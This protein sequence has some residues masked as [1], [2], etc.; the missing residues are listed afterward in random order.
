MRDGCDE[1][2]DEKE[3]KCRSPTEG[4]KARFSS[5]SVSFYSGG[6]HAVGDSLESPCAELRHRGRFVVP[7]SCSS[8]PSVCD[9]VCGSPM[10]MRI[11]NR[12]S[13][14][15]VCVCGAG[16]G[17]RLK[18][19]GRGLPCAEQRNRFRMLCAA[20][21]SRFQNVRLRSLV[22]ATSHTPGPGLLFVACAFW[23]PLSLHA[24]SWGRFAY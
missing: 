23:P 21:V 9:P 11:K 19:S 17:G 20:L 13:G 6:L 8:L 15:A 14:T 4:K 10:R 1:K 3:S 5:Q 22:Y 24:W 2:M 16:R 18:G 7:S 12:S